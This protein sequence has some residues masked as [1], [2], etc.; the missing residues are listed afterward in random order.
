MKVQAL[1][2]PNGMFGSIYVGSWRVSDSGLLNMSGLDSYL[3][4]LFTECDMKIGESFDQF[5]ACYGDGIF[6][7]L[8]TIL[9]RYTMADESEQR[10]NRRLASARQS[11]EHLF[12]LHFNTF[13][14]FSIP[15]RFKLLVHGVEVHIMILNSFFSLN[16]YVC[17]NESPN[18]FDLRPPT[19]EEYLPVNEVLVPA[20]FVSDELLGGVYNYYV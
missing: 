17:F 6:P 13:G 11:V 12:S 9:A 19:I 1:T 4:N 3:S 7:Q 2:L 16:C 20:P 15:H 5:P 14:L 18:N 8:A 10:V